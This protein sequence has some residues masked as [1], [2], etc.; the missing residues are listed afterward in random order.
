MTLVIVPITNVTPLAR[1]VG[2]VE[3]VEVG[4]EAVEAVEEVQEVQEVMSTALLAI[5]PIGVAN[6]VATNVFLDLV[7]LD[8]M[9]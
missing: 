1:N 3:V 5:A 6:R 2:L 8:G 4:V 7:T 9:E